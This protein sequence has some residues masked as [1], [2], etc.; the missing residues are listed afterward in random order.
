MAPSVTPAGKP[1]PQQLQQQ[2]AS[3]LIVSWA[4]FG[5]LC[6]NVSSFVD[7][8]CF[9]AGKS[10]LVVGGDAVAASRAAFAVEA[11]ASVTVVA[12]YQALAPALKHLVKQSSVS[13][14]DRHFEADDLTGKS[15]VF[16][17]GVDSLEQSR[18]IGSLCHA[19]SI[20]VNVSSAAEL[21]DFY[22]MSTY[23]EQSLQVAISTNGNGPRLAAKLRKQIVNSIPS[24]AGSAL[25]AL[26]KLRQSLKIADP[27]LASNSQRL[28]FVNKVSETWS[29]STIATFTDSD[30][31]ALVKSYLANSSELPKLRTGS[32]RVVHSSAGGV[33]DLTVRAFRALS[34]AE[35][36]IA[37]AAVSRDIFDLVTGDLMVVPEDSTVSDSMIHA[38]LRAVQLGQHVVRLTVG[39]ESDSDEPIDVSFFAEKGFEVNILPSILSRFAQA[40]PNVATTRTKVDLE[41]PRELPEIVQSV[42]STFKALNVAPLVSGSP[43]LISGQDAA[44]HVAYA[45]S[46]LSFVYSVLPESSLGKVS[47]EWAKDGV[48][49]ANGKSHKVY[50]IS[51]RTGAGSVVHGAAHNGS[52]VAVLANSAA[53]S[54]MMPA[55]YQIGTEKLPVVI[56]AA[57][58]GV[59]SD[60]FGIYP[61]IA[62]VTAAS[63]TG[64]AAIGS[65]NVKESH[66]LAIVAHVA[67]VASSTPF[68]HFFDGARVA[69]EKCTIPVIDI[70][71]LGSIVKSAISQAAAIRSVPVADVVENV[72]STLSD[73]LGHH[74]RLFEYIGS[75]TAS[76][77]VVA[78]GASSSVV[79]E[80]IAK[81]SA[82]NVGLLKIRLLRPWS[83]RHF[84]AALPRTVKKIVLIDDSKVPSSASHGALF[85]D[86]TGAFY[87]SFWSLPVPA[88]LKGRFAE[89]AENFT[90]GAVESFLRHIE[91]VSSKEEFLIE[92]TKVQVSHPD[93]FEAILWDQQA[94]ETEKVALSA[95]KLLEAQGATSIQ[96]FQTTSSIAVDPVSATHIRFSK[97][98]GASFSQS[99]SLI[100]TANYAA[101]HNVSL[102]EL[103]NVAGSIRA[104][105]VLLLNWAGANPTV[106]ELSKEIPEAVK[107]EIHA[108]KIRVAVVDANKIAFNYTLFRGNKADYRNLVLLAAL[109]KLMDGMDGARALAEIEG[110]LSSAETDNTVFRTKIGAL[111]TA[112]NTLAVFDPPSEWANASAEPKLP[113]FFEP[114]I[115]LKKLAGLDIEDDGDVVGKV[116][117]K[118]Q[119]A[120]PIMFKEAFGVK[121]ALRPDAG[122]KTFIVTVTENRRLTPESYERNV[123]H[124]EFDIGSSGLKYDIGEALG[125]YGQN[126]FNHVQ[127]FLKWYGVSGD[128]IVRFDRAIE[129]TGKV[130]SEFR[131]VQQLFVEVLDVFGKPG[132]KF[133]QSLIEH[134]TVM[135]ERERLGLLTSGEGAD[136]LAELQEQETVSFADVLQMFPSAHPPIEKLISLIP[137]IKPRHYSISSSMNVHPTSVHLLVVVVDWKTK[138]GKQRYGQCTQYLVG[139]RPGTK[140]A[141]SVKP[142]VMKLPPSHEAPVIMAGLGTGMAP[143]RAFVEERAYQKSLGKTVGPMVLYFGA[144][145]RAEEYLYGEE[146]EAYH[147][148]GLLTHLRL[149]FSRDQKEKV[150]IQ[151]KIQ[152]D[153][154]MLGKMILHQGGA[155]YL[156][157]PTWPVPDVRDALVSAFSKFMTVEEA[158]EK[159]EL[160]KEDERYVLEV[161]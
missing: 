14:L 7:W 10:I 149:A 89:G 80:A 157:G 70:T 82:E 140:V 42:E 59:K 129:A 60:S 49:N 3:S 133:F 124:I 105:G 148:D 20:P 95:V 121:A 37:D 137:A 39:R 115:G 104:N 145:H 154:E 142:S 73:H 32:V 83:A 81:L 106:D 130:E 128:Q 48:R 94:D 159:L 109:A 101:V 100:T 161:Y 13:W 146:L 45:L 112:V 26:A 79:H 63:F 102:L 2:P 136:F 71:K 66:D 18:Q 111:R 108:R 61:S 134:A 119:P 126:N 23:K 27:S 74:Y 99:N 92:S 138:S 87:D 53:L 44:A 51:T 65:A 28:T 35:L 147:F 56:H 135:S 152:A 86:V 64:F 15:M 11:G 68:L 17:C 4:V 120:L 116:V 93:I 33:E 52:A 125:V 29:A 57:T 54:Q 123:F 21:S 55:M 114:T 117:P 69:T 85:L 43:K 38:A 88:I 34:E 98:L 110:W 153:S 127:E 156:C 5:A 151:H 97:T 31:A 75:Q 113:V 22:F 25:E 131:T 58:H 150:Y 96:Y 107:R 76:T 24:H 78:V 155:F 67:A 19:R 41:Q 12:P 84:L 143:F 36:V 9:P 132:K 62:D 8:G 118:Y 47:M 16:V 72:M 77:V 30:I 122:E 90:S 139:L 160:L 158:S 144:R 1:V 103:V 141:V 50:E 40:V 91:R 46:D 6:A